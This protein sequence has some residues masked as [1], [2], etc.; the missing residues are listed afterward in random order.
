MPCPLERVNLACHVCQI[1]PS[2]HR[3][4]R[5]GSRSPCLA[6]TERCRGRPYCR[7]PPSS[8]LRVHMRG[9]E[10]LLSR[11]R[12]STPPM[13]EIP[14]LSK[15]QA[16]RFLGRT[17]GRRARQAG[18]GAGQAGRGAGRAGGT[19]SAYASQDEDACLRD[20]RLRDAYEMH[21]CEMHACEMH[22]CEMHA[23][24]REMKCWKRSGRSLITVM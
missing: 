10:P 19:R 3:T 23:C 13:R 12:T 4:Y 24:A 6:C 22:A 21:T 5:P 14:Q 15:T 18:R 16:A 17:G 7:P 20:A 1:T 8:M 9:L 11:S 2:S